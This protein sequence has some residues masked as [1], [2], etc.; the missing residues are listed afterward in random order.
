M[1]N[2]KKQ[3]KFEKKERIKAEKL[4]FAAEMR[5][6]KKYIK[7]MSKS[8]KKAYLLEKELLLA[9]GSK[10]N[11]NSND[12][13]L[14]NGSAQDN[15]LTG[16]D[17]R[18][19][20]DKHKN[21]PVPPRKKKKTCL[22][23]FSSILIAL[24]LVV[25]GVFATALICYNSYA[26]PI[27]QMSFF[28]AIDVAFNLYV[29][30][31]DKIVTNP[32]DPEQDSEKFYNGL[33]ESLRIDKI[34]TINDIVNGLTDKPG[35]E[36]GGGE[37]ST[38]N[39]FLDQL[40]GNTQFDFSTLVN[41]DGTSKP[42]FAVT[43]RMLAAIL[44][45]AFAI[46]SDIAK[47]T[48][49]ED[50][51]GMPLKDVFGVDQIIITPS[52]DDVEN[53]KFKVTLSL[54]AR[55]L[56]TSMLA[57]TGGLPDFAM[58]MI[59][60]LMPNI[61]YFSM[62]MTPGAATAPSIQLN[63]IEPAL[64]D[65]VIIAMDN[66]LAMQGAPS[67]NAT[68]KF[69]GILNNVGQVVHDVFQKVHTLV[70][71]E[72][73]TF[74][75]SVDGG[76]MNIDTLQ[77]MMFA[78]NVKNVTST[79][80]LLM[81]KHLHAA[82]HELSD[83]VSI[84]DYINLLVDEENRTSVQKYNEE[85]ARVFS[86][87]GISNFNAADWTPE[88]FINNISKIPNLINIVDF[89]DSNG[90][91]LY[92]HSQKVL[93]D[94]AH[95]SD[96]A[97]AQILQ[98]QINKPATSGL[99]FPFKVTILELDM[100]KSSAFSGFEIIASMDVK[101]LI[102]SSLENNPLKTLI[103]SL[104]PDNLF[105]K[106]TT[107][108]EENTDPNLPSSNI[109]F[110]FYD[111][112]GNSVA[113]ESDAMLSTLSKIMDTIGSST[114]F[115]DKDVLLKTFDDKIYKALEQMQSGSEQDSAPFSIELAD[116][117]VQL[118]TIYKILSDM[119]DNVVATN[120]MQKVLS[121]YY[122][123][124]GYMNGTTYT[125]NVAPVNLYDVSGFVENQLQKKMFLNTA[126]HI[127][128]ADPAKKNVYNYLTTIGGSLTGA[129]INSHVSVDLFKNNAQHASYSDLHIS[130]LE[131][132]KILLEGDVLKSVETSMA[133]YKNF[134]IANASVDKS[135]NMNL[136]IAGEL[137]TD[138]AASSSGGSG[139][140]ISLNQ[141]ATPFIFIN[142]SIPMS[143][144]SASN[145][146]T[147]I[148][149]ND[150]KNNSEMSALLTILGTSSNTNLNINTITDELDSE[151][152][153]MLAS[154]KEQGIVM[155]TTMSENPSDF[156]GIIGNNI[157]DLVAVKMGGYI[158]PSDAVDRSDERLRSILFKLNN[159][160][161]FLTHSGQGKGNVA[162]GTPPSTP[163]KTPDGTGIIIDDL[164]LGYSL[165]NSINSETSPDK[166]KYFLSKLAVFPSGQNSI[167]G[168][169]KEM[170]MN[171][172]NA[173]EK[174]NNIDTLS[175]TFSIPRKSIASDETSIINQFLPELSFLTVFMDIRNASTVR[176]LTINNLTQA[177]YDYLMSVT[178]PESGES[179]MK[180]TVN[181]AL[182]N[183]FTHTVDINLESGFNVRMPL[184][185]FVNGLSNITT[186]GIDPNGFAY[187]KLTFIP[188]R[189]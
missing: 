158:P 181:S 49:I 93:S 53:A 105:I 55:D 50:T 175:T 132:A 51:L 180:D 33:S 87:Y 26:M 174:F 83:T 138:S 177:E 6:E 129:N 141:F 182:N 139:G 95:F 133:I 3:I 104:F 60:A 14:H 20:K 140:N 16:V 126:G 25:G 71:D 99:D 63:N 106:I 119:S 149:I 17:R 172:F 23:C 5:E 148:T 36:G 135:G 152:S 134:T 130:S 143:A 169:T 35:D 32:Y 112:E 46:S 88:K 69:T 117:G 111:S 183:L 91:H 34:L 107:P 27:T 127:A 29:A 110:N 54:K 62:E 57:K 188:S 59:P 94:L 79:D 171:E 170:Y 156:N 41:F 86:G 163:T 100:I 155:K 113:G 81:V 165:A 115:F 114:V 121:S 151:I 159:P 109:V 18:K 186:D 80:F 96:V 85:I 58:S 84:D 176:D 8:E 15:A 157:Y 39:S 38:G 161:D 102:N 120:D 162:T 137:N 97:L 76:I 45:D 37:G 1:A 101:G 56:I 145:N 40:L 11:A 82:D 64:M 184:V 67:E 4:A 168:F 48:S 65:K 61:I 185:D 150:T 10:S 73:I 123:I 21:K 22:C 31:K 9:G 52:G 103:S 153:T 146:K 24:V 154:F 131:F 122:N 66:I 125:N 42:G 70:G 92:D 124:N 166:G 19:Q 147:T 90:K 47:L 164:L 12:N 72:G 142:A 44:D 2:S 30:D 167:T 43:D 144:E 160:S 13:S 178:T 108:F 77:A 28:E 136:T 78:M 68:G 128:E 187:G 179:A 7:T 118:P 74:A 173:F 189:P 75:S 98:A 89:K 116:Q